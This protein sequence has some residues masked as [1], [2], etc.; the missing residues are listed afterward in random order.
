MK[1][2]RALILFVLFC[3]SFALAG[4]PV[5]YRKGADA[6]SSYRG[7]TQAADVPVDMP[8]TTE[9]QG[10]EPGG[11]HGAEAAESGTTGH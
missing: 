11:V 5:G 6:E 7:A 10:H 4:C 8:Q 3:L 9:G 2:K 1:R